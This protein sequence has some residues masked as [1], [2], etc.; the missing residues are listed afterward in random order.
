MSD[1]REPAG[2]TGGAGADANQAN[3]V[4]HEAERPEPPLLLVTVGTD[5]HPFDR[6]IEWVDRWLAEGPAEHVR[7]VVQHGSAR[8]PKTGEAYEHL[9]HSELQ[10]AMA[11][12]AVIVCHGGPAT[13]TEARRTGHLPIVVPRD[14]ELGEHV[15]DHQLRFARHLS[16]RG[17]IAC[18]DTED[19]FRGALD[20]AHAEPER[21]RFP[22]PSEAAGGVA[23]VAESVRRAGALIDDLL[24]G[25]T[26]DTAQTA[27]DS[28]ERRSG[29]PSVSVVIPTKD[30]PELVRRAVESVL[31]QDYP[32]DIDVVVVFD[33]GEPDQALATEGDH[34]TVSVTANRRTPGLAGG[35]NSG[36]LAVR[37]DLVAFCDDDDVWLPGK[38][39]AQVAAL[40]SQPSAALVCSGI[41]VDYDGT[42]TDRTLDLR[43]VERSDLLRSRLSEL[44][45][46]TFLMRRA[47]LVE[48]FG[49]VEENLPGSYAEDYDMLLRAAS[50]GPVLNIPEVHARIRWHA[51]SHFANRWET[52]ARAL[53]ALLDRHPDFRTVPEG[54][55]RVAGQIAFA[56][57]ALGERRT[58]LR[59]ARGAL[60]ANPLEPRA[61]LAMAVA[62]GAVRA[63]TVLS[64]LHKRGRGL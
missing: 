12:A 42:A 19:A 37:G 3:P 43:R 7:C 34:R 29:W 31:A 16:E 18:C 54:Y 14:P 33:G 61:Y 36:I 52:I 9:A 57:A 20:S 28:G 24:A 17:L 51:E 32:G 58:S 44:H 64:S 22:G 45:P 10:A 2:R 48:G 8:L 27:P 38:L 50:Y 56:R 23:P 5:H 25:R 60:R 35:R 63:D 26:D 53:A 47:A 40:E 30:R 1:A 49:L 6:L 21:F 15:D 62:G 55:A 11:E 41:T 59:W 46:S 4:S 39:L 13:I